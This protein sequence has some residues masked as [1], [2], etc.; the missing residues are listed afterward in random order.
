MSDMFMTERR[1]AMMSEIPT[2]LR[3]K[4]TLGV[5]FSDALCVQAKI[6]CTAEYLIYVMRNKLL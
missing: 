4:C 1:K 5:L 3:V 6:S 2:I